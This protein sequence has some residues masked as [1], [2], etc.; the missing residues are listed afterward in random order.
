MPGTSG[1]TPIDPDD[2]FV[3]V[4]FHDG[5]H[6]LY[7]PVAAAE[8]DPLN[9]PTGD[10]WSQDG[11]LELVTGATIVTRFSDTV[12]VNDYSVYANA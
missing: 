10:L 8:T 12:T 4:S 2:L 11:E 3:L 1:A 6:G 9:G 7:G 5:E